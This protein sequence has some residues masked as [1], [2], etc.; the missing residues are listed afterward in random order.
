MEVIDAAQAAGVPESQIDAEIARLRRG[1]DMS[2]QPRRPLEPRYE[3]RVW[4]AARRAALKAIQAEQLQL[5]KSED[6]A[7]TG[8]RT[9]VVSGSP[10]GGDE[11]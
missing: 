5:L 4:L 8:P 1:R 7:T 11:G 10:K 3:W 9:T 6:P 2:G